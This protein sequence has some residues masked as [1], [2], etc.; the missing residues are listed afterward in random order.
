V[1]TYPWV[2]AIYLLKTGDLSFVKANFETEGSAGATE[3]AGGGQQDAGR[4]L[5]GAVPVRPVGLGGPVL[6]QL[7]AFGLLRPPG[8]QIVEYLGFGETFVHDS[9]PNPPAGPNP[10]RKTPL[11]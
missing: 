7:P 8:A 3:P 6:F 10:P 2:W 5:G 1:W 9:P 11:R 4:Q